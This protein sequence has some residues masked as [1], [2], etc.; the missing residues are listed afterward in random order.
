MYFQCTLSRV[1]GDVK[2]LF[3]MIAIVKDFRLIVFGDASDELIHSGFV[4][5]GG[6]QDDRMTEVFHHVAKLTYFLGVGAVSV[7]GGCLGVRKAH[8]MKSI[9]AHEHNSTILAT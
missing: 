4:F 3:C 8:D 6:I 9:V 7:F 2:E 5:F 1:P